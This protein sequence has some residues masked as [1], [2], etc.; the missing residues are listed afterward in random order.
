M[1]EAMVKFKGRSSL[2]QYMPMKP[3]KED[4]KYGVGVTLTMALHAVSKF[5]WEKLTQWRRALE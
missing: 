4:L 5:T 2:K 3:I 1:D